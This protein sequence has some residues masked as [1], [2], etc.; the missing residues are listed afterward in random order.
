ML[1]LSEEGLPSRKSPAPPSG[2]RCSG[3]SFT[4]I[5]ERRL[6][7]EPDPVLPRHAANLGLIS[8]PSGLRPDLDVADGQPVAAVLAAMIAFDGVARI[9][10]APEPIVIVPGFVGGWA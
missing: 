2:S 5:I 1:S 10:P 8:G 6:T 9:E 4:A 3:S 7:Y